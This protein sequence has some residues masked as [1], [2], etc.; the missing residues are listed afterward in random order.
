MLFDTHV[1]LHA[2]AFA[3]DRDEVLARARAAGVTRFIAICDRVSS[4]PAVAAIA[5]AHADVW[6]TVGAHPHH[7]ADHAGLAAADLV[8]LAEHPRVC[9]IGETGLDQHYGY[10]PLDAQEA[11]FRQ[12]IAA[13]RAT[14]LPVVIHT[15]EADELTGDVLE[16]EH[17]RGAFAMLMHC[18]T[19]GDRLAARALALGARFSVSGILS[20][21]G[22]AAV[23][24]V[25]A[26]L[27]RDRVILETDCPYLAPVPQ[28]GRRNEPAFLTHVCAALAELWDVTTDEAA[29]RT[30]AT[31]LDLFRRVR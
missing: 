11:A 14:G 10:S 6:C 30:T 22:A 23:R 19:G 18:Y 31:A 1:N 24:A 20:F 12:H 13:A 16:D 5:D 4:F 28:R 8:R 7:A 15:R 9:A 17:A 25:I 21:K 2:E 27:P 26:G 29:A 3:G